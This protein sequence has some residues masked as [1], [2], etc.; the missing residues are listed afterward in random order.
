MQGWPQGSQWVTQDAFLHDLSVDFER[1]AEL[2]TAKI[3]S[4]MKLALI[5]MWTSV[6]E[7]SRDSSPLCGGGLVSTQG[8][9]TQGLC[10]D[11]N[12][13]SLCHNCCSHKGVSAP[14]PH[15]QNLGSVFPLWNHSSTW[16]RHGDWSSSQ[17]VVLRTAG[18][19]GF[20]DLF[21][22]LLLGA[23]QLICPFFRLLWIGCLLCPTQGTRNWECCLAWNRRG[24][25]WRPEY[26]FI[27]TPGVTAASLGWCPQQ[28]RRGG[29]D[30]S[31]PF[32]RWGN[33]GW[34]RS[35]DSHKPVLK[36]GLQSHSFSLTLTL[37]V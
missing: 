1:V 28:G 22:N 17:A 30:Q 12:P 9:S 19:L 14:T 31:F 32:S 13:S 8:T 24:P 35:S 11:S 25:P 18:S 10:K 6:C 27:V 36:L 7:T 21:R 5:S 3:R 33:R 23:K 34:R 2:W 16:D 4:W 20:G 26:S 15:L 37:N 29:R